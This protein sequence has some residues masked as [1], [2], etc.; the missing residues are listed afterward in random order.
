MRVILVDV[1]P[2]VWRRVLVAGTIRLPTLARILAAGNKRG[3]K[4]LLVRLNIHRGLPSQ[5][6]DH[7]GYA[8]NR[9]QAAAWVKENPE[10]VI[11]QLRPLR[12]Q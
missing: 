6:Y 2:L 3:A 7:V 5:K 11:H 4:G 12:Y 1:D 8:A 10:V 9:R